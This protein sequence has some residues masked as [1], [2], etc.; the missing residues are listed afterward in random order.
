MYLLGV[1]LGWSL[2]GVWL[3]IALDNYA[4]ALVLPWWYRSGCWVREV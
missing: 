2:P 3:A 4:R 1:R